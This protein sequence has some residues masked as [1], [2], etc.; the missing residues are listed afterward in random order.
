MAQLAIAKVFD[1]GA[2]PDG[3]PF[4]VMEYVPSSPITHYCDEKRLNTKQRLE[5][6]NGVRDSVQHARQKAIIHRDLKPGTIMMTEIDEKAVPYIIDFGIA[7]ATDKQPDNETMVTQVRMHVGTPGYIAPEQTDPTS[8]R[9]GAGREKKT[10]QFS[11]TPLLAL[12]TRFR[13]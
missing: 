11:R 2:T 7:K 6:F 10:G 13:Y 1:A 9:H 4:F 5:L 12:R 8:A 3:Q